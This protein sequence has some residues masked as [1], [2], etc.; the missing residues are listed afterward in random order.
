MG[1]GDP[2]PLEYGVGVRRRGRQVRAS[3]LIVQPVTA[4]PMFRCDGL[5]SRDDCLVKGGDGVNV[6]GHPLR[7]VR[8]HRCA[9][10]HQQVDRLRWGCEKVPA[11]RREQLVELLV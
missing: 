5:R 9:A 7:P 6:G 10:H 2:F 8:H 1:D 3:R 4:E 11:G